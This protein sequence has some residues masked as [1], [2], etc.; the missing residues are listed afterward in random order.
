M[1]IKIDFQ[2]S[3][4]FVGIAI[5][6]I[7]L[8][9]YTQ[10][11]QRPNNGDGWRVL[12]SAQIIVPPD[13]L[14]HLPF[15]RLY[16]FKEMHAIKAVDLVPMSSTAAIV[17]VISFAERAVTFKKFDFL[18]VT[19]FYLAMYVAG[20]GLMVVNNRPVIAV[21]ILL[22]L[23]NPYILAHF[24]SPYEEGLFIALCPMLSALLMNGVRSE[25]LIGR[26]IALSAATSKVQFIPAFLLGL[27]GFRIKENTDYLLLSVLIMCAVVMKASKFNEVNGYNR[28]FNG[29][30]YSI[31]QVSTWP[32]YDFEAR[33]S[34][35][36]EMTE[37]KDIVFPEGSLKIKQY[38]GSS[39]WPTGVKLDGDEQKFIFSHVGKWFWQ[40]ISLN[41]QYGYRLLTEPVL[42]MGKADYRMNYI[43]RS[44]LSQQWLG[45]HALAMQ[46]FGVIFIVLSIGGLIIAIRNRNTKHVL[47]FVFLL[48]Y[49]VMVVFGDGYY[50]FEK[51]TFPAMF[52]GVVFGLGLVFKYVPSLQS[53]RV[54][55][56]IRKTPH[57]NRRVKSRALGAATLQGTENHHPV[58]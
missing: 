33:R 28:Y 24:N 25:G 55:S 43:F 5:I 20:M 47:V 18:W 58:K 1:R 49:P 6:F 45:F 30:S 46:N 40:T 38:W 51:H 31:S 52:L 22:L 21:P 57:E 42:T 44:D 50:E 56:P 14:N 12:R 8:V 13:Y 16:E 26:G 34:L 36:N 4:A 11:I 32:A 19:A 10:K 48:L 17:E 23:V 29:L 15:S 7:G 35:A 27:K 54:G 37:T 39:F 53:Y 9:L 41:P 3:A 2:K